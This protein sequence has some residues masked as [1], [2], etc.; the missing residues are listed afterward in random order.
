[1]ARG[2]AGFDALL[3]KQSRRGIEWSSKPSEYPPP[4]LRRAAKVRATFYFVA[5]GTLAA[6]LVYQ[7]NKAPA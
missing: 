7:G 2:I 5:A 4:P 3:P 1:M 6:V